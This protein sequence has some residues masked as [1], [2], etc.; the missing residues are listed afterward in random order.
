MSEPSKRASDILDD[1]RNVLRIQR[2]IEGLLLQSCSIGDVEKAI[3]FARIDNR[4]R[5]DQPH[6]T[7]SQ[8]AAH[9]ATELFS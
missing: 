7:V 1:T 2:L 8:L 5:M 4:Y 9:L 6:V 3:A